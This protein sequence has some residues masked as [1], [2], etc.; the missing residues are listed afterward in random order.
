M[1]ISMLGPLE[2]RA[3]DGAPVEI[4][5]ARLRTLLIL[6]ALAPGRVVTTDRLID[7]VWGE[8]P[9]AEATNA[10]QAL[11][12]RLRRALPE[13]AV[14][15]H[16]AG[17]RL[18]VSPQDVD[19]QRFEELAT[20][21]NGD[22]GDLLRT[23]LELWRGEALADVAGAA[24]AQAPRAR[25]VELRL[26]ALADRIEDDLLADRGDPVAEL[27]SLVAEHPLHER[28]AGLL[29]RA[30]ARVGRSGDALAVYARTRDALA[31][32]LG[33]DPSPE[34]AELHLALLRG[35]RSE[36]PSRLTNLRASLTSF[37]GRDRDLARVSTMMGESR[38]VTLT[39]PG[40]SGKTRLATEVAR[41][42]L[43][44]VS[45]VWLVEFAPVG[46][47]AELPQ[48]V[49]SALGLRVDALLGT[50][51]PVVGE[52][53]ERLAAALSTRSLLLVLDNCEHVV[54][55]AAELVDR[56]LGEC[57]GLRVLATSREPLGI[58]GETLWPVDPLP[59]P[60]AGATGDEALGYPSMRLLADRA[61]SARPDLATDEPTIASMVHICRA[62][63]GMPLAIELA[64]A[65]LRTMSPGQLATRLHDRF[66]LLTGGSRMALPRH[67]TLRAVVDWSWELLD[68]QERVLLRRLAVFSGGAT[69][70]AAEQVCGDVEHPV[71]LE[72]DR[73]FD[74]LSALVDKSLVVLVDDRYRLLET[75]KAY[76]LER[77][78]E[79]GE[80]ERTRRAHTAFFGRLVE[81]AEPHLWRAEQ[82]VWIARLTADHDNLNAALRAAVAAGDSETALRF[83]GHVAGYWWLAGHKV[84]GGEL[85]GEVLAMP[86]DDVPHD[87]RAVAFGISALIAMDGLRD[88]STAEA[89]FAEGV[90]NAERADRGH[91]LVRLILALQ[92]VWH[93]YGRPGERPD[94]DRVSEL[95]DDE[96]PWVRGTGRVMR[97]HAALNAGQS[98]AQAEADFR[99][100]LAAF[101]EAGERWG[102]AFTLGS[103]ADLM[104]WRGELSAAADQYRE[105]IELVAALDAS[106]DMVTF[107][108]RLAALLLQLDRPAESA[109]VLEQAQHDADR[110]GLPESLAGVAQARAE[111]ARWRG[112]LETASVEM[113]RAAVVV[114]HPTVPPQFRAIV[115]AGRGFQAAA[116]GRA[117]EAA[118]HHAEALDWAVRSNDAPVIAHTLVGI[119][120]TSL[121][122][123][124]ARHA[125]RLLGASVAIR[126]VPDLSFVD[127]VRVE[128]ATRAALGEEEFAEWVAR[129]RSATIETVLELAGVTPAV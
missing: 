23:A 124:E 48:A 7:G 66:R 42:L 52:P 16:P 82:L 27:E 112:D 64:A 28:F 39:G 104:A 50:G 126:G 75:I 18:A 107:R 109:A 73:V 65:R 29:M 108:L 98:H 84:E 105:A 55:A 93:L 102:M 44:D 72:P 101:R 20:S 6:L 38:L 8:H 21:G 116:L 37:V 1:R 83:L 57:P 103:L 117:E 15:S 12:S 114:T 9:P 89:W 97:A 49:L 87:V 51:G 30:L 69:L 76:S 35:E 127:G 70:E 128:A 122:R 91:P 43:E 60:P 2:V 34:L 41:A 22:R 13:P 25:L 59:L 78:A 113:A 11:V 94:L 86:A 90:R 61:R 26:A 110:V 32:Q 68:D 17:Y 45:E 125:A 31:E 100:A 74:V 129:G 92:D 88:Q 63:D 95:V 36:R 81:A 10:L 77:L 80:R 120:E 96:D 119:A 53:V 58:T 14:E 106:D 85:A 121:N 33:A 54:A 40:G 19:V 47:G 111:F 79:A 123:G 118:A 67:Q 71:G 99:R 3:D 5:G 24:F 56:L 4:T 62:L 115:C 46:D